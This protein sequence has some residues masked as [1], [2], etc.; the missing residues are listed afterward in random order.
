MVR[1]L[2]ESTEGLTSVKKSN[3]ITER[4]AR[5]ERAQIGRV[6]P[7]ETEHQR[8]R[9]VAARDGYNKVYDLNTGFV[10]QDSN[11][12]GISCMDINNILKSYI[13]TDISSFQSI[14]CNLL[15]TFD[16]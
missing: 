12:N 13:I 1:H 7:R 2:P 3:E 4:V 11:L 8:T 5:F 9:M 6:N 15:F 16:T 14:N 10:L